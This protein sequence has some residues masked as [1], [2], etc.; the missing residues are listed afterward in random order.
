M[1]DETAAFL[2][3]LCLIHCLATPLLM[4]AG[5]LGVLG[6]LFSA[7]WVHI[8]L[9]IPIAALALISLPQGRKRHGR[10][11]PA[12]TGLGGLLLLI[13]A[14]FVPHDTEALFSVSGGLLL[15]GAHLANRLHCHE[16]ATVETTA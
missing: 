14:F 2:S 6:S 9:I 5:G 10:T 3:G 1:K 13:A 11:Y 16:K 15:M 4:T 12:L 8:A 7:E